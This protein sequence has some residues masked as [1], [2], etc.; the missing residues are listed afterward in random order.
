M[1]P[2]VRLF[3]V[4][5]RVTLAAV[6]AA[7]GCAQLAGIDSTVALGDALAVTRVSIGSKVVQAPLDPTGLSAT[8]FVA[9]SDPTGF[10]RVM[11][12]ADPRHDRWTSR[13][14]TAAPV[15]FTLPDVPAPIPRLFAF[16]AP[17]LSVAYGVL[18]HPGAQPAPADGTFMVNVALDAPVAM[19]DAFQTYAV[20]P[21]LR[22]DFAAT[23]VV[24]GAT[25]LAPP[26]FGFTGASDRLSGRAQLDAVTP[27]DAF[28]VLRYAGAAL[29]GVAATPAFS[30][31]AG[32]TMVPAA[33]MTPV[34]PNQT[35]QMTVAPP[36]IAA[37]YTGVV[38]AVAMLQIG[39]NLIA[40]PGYSL[41]L[42]FG[43]VL[44]S[45]GLAMTDTGAQV[46]YANPFADRGWHTLLTLSAVES[47]VYA[48]MGPMGV[49]T[50]ITLFAGLNQ[51]VEPT[52]ALTL[53]L[54][55]GLPQAIT[56]DG[57]RLAPDGLTIKQPTRFVDV[58]FTIDTPML[59]TGPAPSPTVYEID[60]YDLVVDAS[61]MALDR[62]LVYAGVSDAPKFALPPELFQVGHSYSLRAVADLDGF[63]GSARGDFVDRQLPLEQGFLD[64]GVLTVVP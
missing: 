60:V 63:P 35:L 6:A 43:P 12:I 38:P 64:G 50:P 28:L 42:N 37:R 55:A 30:Q 41:A 23:D 13:L 16:P 22:H 5:S 11:A 44:Q 24:V 20:G 17:Q 62:Q 15:Q 27:D 9:S 53:E 26:A 19:G 36:V 8:Y 18:E 33:T 57:V 49:P 48:P 32:V 14:R 34:T 10:D 61:A 51:F 7:A 25:Q 45:G 39:W 47:R 56:L 1:A 58:S 54:P 4:V 40:A 29:T 46:P 3:A 31:T 52:Q 21:W 2:M 59:S